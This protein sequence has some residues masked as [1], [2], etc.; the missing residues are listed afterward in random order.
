TAASW[1]PAGYTP[2]AAYQLTNTQLNDVAF[3]DSKILGVHFEECS[4]FL[5]S[6][7]FDTCNLDYSTFYKKKLVQTTFN[8]SS[9]KQVDFSEADLSKSSFNNSNLSETLFFRTNL[10]EADFRSAQNFSID[11]L[12]N[13][14]KKA[15]FSRANLEGLLEKFQL[16]IF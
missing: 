4:D 16:K 9:L 3:K 13:Q 14:L 7:S 10:T 15:K 11:P 6:V 5:F 1:T 12:E 8:Q 2:T